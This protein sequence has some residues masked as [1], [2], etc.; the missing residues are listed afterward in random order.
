MAEKIIKQE[1]F[2]KNKYHIGNGCYVGFDLGFRL[3]RWQ[4]FLVWLGFKNRW[5]DMSCSTVFKKLPNGDLKVVD[6]NLF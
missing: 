4:R 6:V 5:Q 1:D 3:N 2:S